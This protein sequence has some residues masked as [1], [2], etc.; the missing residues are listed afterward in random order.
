MKDPV[1]LIQ[2]GIFETFPI[3]RLD[4]SLKPA[5]QELFLCQD[6]ITIEIECIELRK[7]LADV[8]PPAQAATGL[9]HSAAIALP[10]AARSK[11]LAAIHEACSAC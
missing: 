8:V 11:T 9:N 10:G 2:S 3:D 7:Y 6:T 5:R 1:P 4:P